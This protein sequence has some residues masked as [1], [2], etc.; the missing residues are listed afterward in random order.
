MG[1]DSLLNNYA[2]DHPFVTGDTEGLNRV[3]GWNNSYSPTEHDEYEYEYLED[4]E[5]SRTYDEWLSIGRQVQRGEKSHKS[6]GKALFYFS[7]TKPVETSYDEE[8][9]WNDDDELTY[10]EWQENGYQVMR[11]EKSHRK[12]GKALFYFSQTMAI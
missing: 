9:E 11:G 3:L 8:R 5:D 12:N 4:E 7:Q 2:P 1:K 6:N 10:E